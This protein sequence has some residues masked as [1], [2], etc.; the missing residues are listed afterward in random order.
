M[1]FFKRK[2]VKTPTVLQME[3]LECGAASLAMI[4][5]YYRKYV[6]LEILRVECGV[7]RDGTKASNLIKAA[8][9]FG[10]NGSGYKMEIEGL[11]NVKCPAIIFWNFNHFVVFEGFKGKSAVINDPAVGRRVVSPEDFDE[12]F[13][14]VVLTFEKTEEFKSSGSRITVWSR[15]KKRISGFGG[16]LSFLSMLNILLFIPGF[17]TPAF[18]RFFIDEILVPNSLSLIKPLLTVMAITSVFN[19]LTSILQKKIYVAFHLKIALMASSRF[20]THLMKMPAQF[21]VQRLPGELC[22]RLASCDNV[23]SLISGQLV[24]LAINL[25]SAVFFLVLMV[26]YDIPLTI[27]SVSLTSITVVIFLVSSRKLRDKSFKLQMDSGKLSGMTMSGIEMIESLKASGSENDF[28]MQWSG[29]Q[30]KSILETQNLSKIDRGNS[31][32]PS[33][34]SS[35]LNILIMTVGAFR[36]MDGYMTVGMLM[37]F[38]TLLS[39]F[40]TPVNSFL[41]FGKSLMSTNADMQRIDDVMEYPVPKS[42]KDEIE[43][44]HNDE[45]TELEAVEKLEGYISIQN[46]VFGYSPLS[47]PLINGLNLELTPG[48]RVALV[49]A[50][51]SGKSTIGKLI[52]NIYSPWSGEILFDG[53]KLSEINRKSFSASVSVVDQ[54]IFLFEGT[55]KDNITMWNSSIPKEVYVQAAKDAC[56]HE[57]IASRPD[58]YFAYVEEGGRNFSGGQRQ[59]I[60]IARALANNPSILIMDEAT[61]ALD[62][63]TE[64]LVAQN[65]ARRGCSSIIIAHRL[66]TIR[67][68]DEI[69]VL[70]NGNVVQR[71]THDELLA[72]E[73]LYKNLVKTM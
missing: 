62:A 60:E 42:F 17:V 7:S 15:I 11:R 41:A 40:T 34:I 35:L 21:F 8:K 32:A 2:R 9:K 43:E 58:G 49:G 51:G 44:N 73:G 5:A 61:S 54:S 66:S 70:E 14:G 38:N 29:Q 18:S 53:K 50:T 56:L 19:L 20:I 12:S 57:V 52:A 13:T 27:I 36:V 37:A 46:M 28:F 71:G 3:A 63:V 69:I 55:I 64:Q 39:S 22:N 68:C 25:I 24:S 47:P 6:S 59:R 45:E 10:L 26:L 31:V 65:I 16:V 67:D 33:V 23:S 48:K 30:A 72:E 1:S 4:L